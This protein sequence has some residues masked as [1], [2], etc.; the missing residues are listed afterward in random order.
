[1][2]KRFQFRLETLL[3]V[4]ELREREA[5]RS[6]GAKLAEIARLDTLN[7]DT[8]REIR[9]QT[10][11]SREMQLLPTVDARTLA[12]ERSWIAY[13]RRQIAGRLHMQAELR[14]ELAKLQ[15]GMREAHRQTRTVEKLRERRLTDHKRAERF[16]EGVEADE[17]ARRLHCWDEL[18][19][20]AQPAG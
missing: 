8:E 9:E 7:S 12:R 20:G 6:V 11:R 19:V 17:L 10:E 14:T 4:R 1:M 5:K 16:R 2:A 13:L 3:R 18:S 15:D